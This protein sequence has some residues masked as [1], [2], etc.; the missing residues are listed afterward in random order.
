M[1]VFCS[2]FGAMSPGIFRGRL[3]ICKVGGRGQVGGV[4]SP[5][6]MRGWLTRE[7]HGNWGIDPLKQTS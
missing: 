1:G 5:H 2:H 4:G 7:G 3:Y 6:L